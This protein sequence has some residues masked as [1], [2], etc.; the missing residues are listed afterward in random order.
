SAGAAG[1]GLVE[2]DMPGFSDAENLEVN[3]ACRTNGCLVAPC[4]FCY[5]F[6]RPVSTRQVDVV[7]IDVHL[8]K[9]ILPHEPSVGMNTVPLHGVV[10][11]QVERDDVPE[12]QAFIPVHPHEFT[13]NANGR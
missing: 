10:L 4:C 9:E 6:A 7:R 12:A 13:I 8:G 11:I 2:T 3:A 5:L 1:P